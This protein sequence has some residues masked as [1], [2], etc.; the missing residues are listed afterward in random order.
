MGYTPAFLGNDVQFDRLRPTL[1]DI[2]CCVTRQTVQAEV[3]V[4]TFGLV[5]L[6][7]TVSYCERLTLL[8]CCTALKTSCSG[9]RIYLVE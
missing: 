4:A 2:L 6:C 8:C 1:P 7:P 5:A 9:V 3:N